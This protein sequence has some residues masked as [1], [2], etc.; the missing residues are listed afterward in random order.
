MNP[1]D[2]T[3]YRILLYLIPIL[4]GMLAFIGALMVKQLM[5]LS[6]SVGEIKVTISA[7]AAKHD[8][9]EKRVDKLENNIA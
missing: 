3:I 5:K 9:L 1:I 2:E 4:L 7:I 6:D 8:N